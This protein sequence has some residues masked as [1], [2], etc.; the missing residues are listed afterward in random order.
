MEADVQD[1]ERAEQ[2]LEAAEALALE[3]RS[4]AVSFND[5]ADALGVSR[6]LLYVYF[7]SAPAIF[8]ALFVKH[9]SVLERRLAELIASPAGYR[10]H[11]VALNETYLDYCVDAG[12]ILP[13]LLRETQN[14]SPLG[15]AGRAYFRKLLRIL[16]RH[17]SQG[18]QIG[19]RE[20]FVFLE[21]I[22]AIPESLARLVREKQI[23][24]DTAKRTC[25]RLTDAAIGSFAPVPAD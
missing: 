8:D 19:T 18:L 22:A 23:D 24:E 17:T 20:S 10:D 5:I 15:T 12:S 2:V 7:D 1:S 3:R 25:K 16:T 14:D 13:L 21:L 4:L 6:S 9:A 11:A